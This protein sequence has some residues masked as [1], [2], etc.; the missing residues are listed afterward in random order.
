MTID[1]ILDL[2]H[3]GFT[4]EEINAME[5]PAP[6]PDPA[7]AP[8]A[9][10]EP[11]P[12]PAPAPEPTPANDPAPVPAGAESAEIAALKAQ[13]EALT[14]AVQKNNIQ[15]PPGHKPDEIETEVDIMEK[16]LDRDL[17]I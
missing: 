12:E 8:A 7:P 5:S 11:A 10:P 3:A 13:I 6:A 2:L 17:L 15:N 14:A 16:M 9:S 4:K 1:D